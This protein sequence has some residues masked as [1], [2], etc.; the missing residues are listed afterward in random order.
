MMTSQAAMRTVENHWWPG[1]SYIEAMCHKDVVLCNITCDVIKLCA[2][3]LW[4]CRLK[5][6][7]NLSWSEVKKKSK[8]LHHSAAQK[9]KQEVS[10]MISFLELNSAAKS[11][12]GLPDALSPLYPFDVCVLQC[13]TDAISTNHGIKSLRL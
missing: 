10:M 11:V 3:E 8:N 1:L 6:W 7:K 12:A 9:L 4:A 5:L 2:L 13:W